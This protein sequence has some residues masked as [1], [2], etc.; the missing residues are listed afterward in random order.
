MR[1][2]AENSVSLNYR[3]IFAGA[4]IGIA[5]YNL[6]FTGF[7]AFGIVAGPLTANYQKLAFM[8]ARTIVM[9][10]S[11]FLAS[12]IA[13]YFSR[14]KNYIS[15]IL[16][17]LVSMCLVHIF[18]NIFLPYFFYSQILNSFG[19]LFYLRTFFAEIVGWF[20]GFIAARIAVKIELGEIQIK[21]REP[22]SISV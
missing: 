13:A 18:A 1:N 19:S 5:A 10:I 6:L 4:I 8:L 14:A 7:R 9:I 16:N 2:H 20:A 21:T 15:G 17:G 12:F 3:I 11:F 22:K